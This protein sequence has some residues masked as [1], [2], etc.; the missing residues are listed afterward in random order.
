[1]MDEKRDAGLTGHQKGGLA[2]AA[3]QTD[4]RKRE[5]AQGA[6]LARWGAKATHRG[7]FKESLASTWI[8]MSWTIQI[9]QP[10]LASVGWG[11]RSGLELGGQR[12]PGSCSARG[13]AHYV[14]QI[15]AKNSLTH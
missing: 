14:G 9:R 15:W 10:S 13:M 12:L 8:A 5:I 2:R 7:N 11:Q 1:M 4:E 3:V 6:A